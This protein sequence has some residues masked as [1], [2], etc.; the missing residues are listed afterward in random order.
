[1][2]KILLISDTHSY[3]DNRLLE[4][5]EWADEVWHAGDWGNVELSDKI[6]EYGKKIRGVYG[7]I[8][9]ATL[10]RMYPKISM[11]RVEGVK[12]GMVHIGGSPS[13]YKPDALELFSRGLPDVFITGHSH[14]LQVKR[15]L[16]RNNMLFLNPGAA[17]KHGFHLVQTALRFEIADGKV[18]N[19]QVIEIGKRAK[20]DNN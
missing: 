11:F 10:R 4:H 15:D 18:H 16:K 17:G 14:I 3:L 1:M 13:K 2:M 20:I 9:G 8:D 12:V 5:I 6:A 19:M 7:N